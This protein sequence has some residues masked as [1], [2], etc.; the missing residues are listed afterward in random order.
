MDCNHEVHR[1]QVELNESGHIGSTCTSL[2][3]NSLAFLFQ[4]RIDTLAPETLKDTLRT[5][6][7]PMA[8][9]IICRYI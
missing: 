8:A 5:Q 4:L 2:I 9:S 1:L 3:I 6:L 7:I